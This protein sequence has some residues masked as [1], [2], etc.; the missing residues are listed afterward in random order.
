MRFSVK[1]LLLLKIFVVIISEGIFT[2][3]EKLFPNIIKIALR[4]I[5][6]VW[7]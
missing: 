7:K 5:L 4:D 3:S 6:F 2:V 1:D